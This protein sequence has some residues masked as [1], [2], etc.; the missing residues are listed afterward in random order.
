MRKLKKNTKTSIYVVILIALVI[1]GALWILSC[2]SLVPHSWKTTSHC[3]FNP[4]ISNKNKALINE[5]FATVANDGLF[6]LLGKK[7]HLEDMGE[8]LSKEV[9]DLTYWAY[10]LSDPKLTQDMKI[11]QKS[12]AKYNGFIEG[13][14]NRIMKECQDPSCFLSQ[15]AEFSQYVHLP[16][17]T[18]VNILKEC[19]AND[20]QDVHAFKKFLD[21]LF[22]GSGEY[23][24]T[25]T[26]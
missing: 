1:G 8:I 7:S 3:E 10:V 11:I 4:S 22:A 14:R 13:T 15:A 19:I 2:S 21:Y 9:P 26:P 24:R 25:N 16:E 17:D 20:G 18:T 6:S 5:T 12:S 23:P